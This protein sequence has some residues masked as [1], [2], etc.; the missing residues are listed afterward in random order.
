[1]KSNDDSQSTSEQEN[2]DVSTIQRKLDEALKKTN[3]F[4]NVS[5]SSSDLFNIKKLTDTKT[6]IECTYTRIEIRF[7]SE[8]MKNLQWN[9]AYRTSQS[10]FYLLFWNNKMQKLID[11]L[12]RRKPNFDK[13]N[14]LDYMY[15]QWT[16][17]IKDWKP[18]YAYDEDIFP[19]TELMIISKKEW[20]IK[21]LIEQDL[22]DKDKLRWKNP[23]FKL[24]WWWIYESAQEKRY[25]TTLMLLAITND[26]IKLLYSIL[27]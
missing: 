4:Q 15:S 7:I 1:M 21:R 16:I 12:R 6:L 25:Y 5:D 14:I 20:F 10:N 19:N 11:L 24:E 2:S 17:F 8:A 18:V 22:I 9:W 23:Y 26:P 27:K 3:W 13:N